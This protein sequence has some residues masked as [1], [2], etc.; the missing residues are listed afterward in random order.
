MS[1]ILSF[2]EI[3]LGSVKRKTA[4]TDGKKRFIVDKNY[5]KTLP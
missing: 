1:L 4:V 5:I 3:N 2:H